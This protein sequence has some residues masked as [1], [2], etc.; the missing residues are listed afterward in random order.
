MKRWDGIITASGLVQFLSSGY[1]C[2]SLDD[3]SSGF[4]FFMFCPSYIE[5]AHHPKM[6]EQLIRETFG[7]SKLSEETVK[8]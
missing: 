7:D 1:I 4:T 3:K 2:K 8:F 6:V 5:G